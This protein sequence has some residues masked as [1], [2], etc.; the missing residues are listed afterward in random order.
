MSSRTAAGSWTWGIEPARRGCVTVH[1]L[2]Q[3]VPTV[4]GSLDGDELLTRLRSSGLP[5]QER[6]PIS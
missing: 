1:D 5:W 6:Q 2:V 3:Q 4:P